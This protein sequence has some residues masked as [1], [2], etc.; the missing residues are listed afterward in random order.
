MSGPEK[1]ELFSRAVFSMQTDKFKKSGRF[2]LSAEKDTKIHEN[3]GKIGGQNSHLK[4]L[5]QSCRRAKF[6]GLA[7]RPT[8]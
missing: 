2:S 4:A 5:S 1:T 3:C 6:R 8:L 7:G